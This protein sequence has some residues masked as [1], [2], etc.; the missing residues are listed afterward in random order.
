MLNKSC[1]ECILAGCGWCGPVQEKANKFDSCVAGDKNGAYIKSSC[2]AK[3]SV[4]P[5]YCR[6]ARVIPKW[7]IPVIVVVLILT[8]ALVIATYVVDWKKRV[9]KKGF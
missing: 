7:L 8:A 4:E 6:Y 9:T 2:D 1:G 3:F 5:T